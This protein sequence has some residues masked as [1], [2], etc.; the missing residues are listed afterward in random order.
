MLSRLSRLL[1]FHAAS[2]AASLQLPGRVEP[3]RFLFDMLYN[4][5]LELLDQ[6]ECEVGVDIEVRQAGKKGLGVFALRTLEAGELTGRYSAPVL[7][8]D[9]SMRATEAGTTSDMY[10]FSLDGLDW[11]LD[12][13][14]ATR[15]NWLRYLNHS[16]RRDNCVPIPAN[17]L[18]FNY[19]VLFQVSR[20]I[21]A[22][23]ELLF[24]Y[25]PGYW[26]R[27]YPNR[28]DPRRVIIDYF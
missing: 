24:D 12:A 25:G 11:V 26:D 8:M 17:V 28:L 5:Q 3:V 1:L 22:G 15:S 4:F 14:D 18:G 27:L 2:T 20:Q 23:D 21:P 10:S 16:R 19:A 7:S 6:R 13:E 9:D